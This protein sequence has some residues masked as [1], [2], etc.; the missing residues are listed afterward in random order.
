MRDVLPELLR[1]WAAGHSAG[2]ATVVGTW[3]S[4][5]RTP[6]ASMLVDPYGEVTGSVSG[7]CVEADVYHLAADPDQPPILRRYGVSDDDA[8][9]VGLTCGG[10]IEILVERISPATFPA[11]GEVA[12]AIE[13]GVPVALV[14]V[15]RA[16]DPARVGRRLA[17]WA[18]HHAGTL[19]R[20]D[21]DAALAEAARGGLAD[22]TG[23]GPERAV[24]EE[25][26]GERIEVFVEYHRPPPRMIVFGAVDFA[27]ELARIGTFL[28]YAVT[29]CDARAVFA[30]ARRFPAEADVV[31][32][33]PHRYLAAEAEAGRI[34]RRT[35]LSVLTHDARFDVPILEVALRLPVAYVGAMGSRRTHDDRLRRLRAAGL[36]D[37]ELAG[38]RSPIGLDLGAR[39]PQETA[40]SIAAELIAARHGGTGLPLSGRGGA[41]HRRTTEA[42]DYG[43]C[44]AGGDG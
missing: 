11:L 37:A 34:D 5:P 43:R 18:D 2:L 38:L 4:A 17:V 19:G 44:T 40:V 23:A 25:P 8:L 26:G 39:T 33:Q 41:I 14:T 35:V 9:A 28:G 13:A 42:V 31:V 20:A 27:V 29:V 36:G 3:H 1:W 30:T 21:T 22:A 24:H 7:G 32:A 10:V 6:G 12:E 15:L 16:A